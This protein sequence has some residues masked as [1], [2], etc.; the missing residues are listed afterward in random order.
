MAKV[1]ETFVEKEQE[2]IDGTRHIITNIT[3][4]NVCLNFC[5]DVIIY[6]MKNNVLFIRQNNF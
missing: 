4:N 6:R 3:Y 5:Y 2:S 1:K